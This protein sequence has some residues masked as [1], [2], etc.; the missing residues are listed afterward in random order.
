M[1]HWVRYRPN[2]CK[3]ADAKQWGE[4]EAMLNNGRFLGFE[5]GLVV[6]GKLNEIEPTTSHDFGC[7]LHEERKDE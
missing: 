6:D 1:K 4:C 7:V 5:Y 2:N 3:W